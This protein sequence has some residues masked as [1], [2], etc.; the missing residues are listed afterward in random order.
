MSKKYKQTSVAKKRALAG[1]NLMAIVSVLNISRTSRM[2]SL[3]A[4][5]KQHT[6]DLANIY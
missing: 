4:T 1:S 6:T 5:V 2:M 3:A